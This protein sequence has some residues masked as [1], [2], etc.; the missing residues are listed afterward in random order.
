MLATLGMSPRLGELVEEHRDNHSGRFR[1]RMSSRLF[2]TL[3]GRHGT[4][5]TPASSFPTL[6]C[7]LCQAQAIGQNIP[8]QSGATIS[9]IHVFLQRQAS[10][11]FGR[12]W[13]AGLLSRAGV[14][15]GRERQPD[16]NDPQGPQTH[17]PDPPW[18]P[19]W[20][21]APSWELGRNSSVGPGCRRRSESLGGGV[22]RAGSSLCGRTSCSEGNVLD[23]QCPATGQRTGPAHPNGGR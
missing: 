10:A 22:A 11:S 6:P 8:G 13:G 4:R 15:A 21:R 12:N 7:F 16:R 2:L 23:L 19:A 3:A 5:L 18:T 9:P 14:A 20:C 1:G 17:W